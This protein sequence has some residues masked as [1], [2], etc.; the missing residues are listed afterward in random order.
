[1]L[2]Q[3]ATHSNVS[4]AKPMFIERMSGVGCGRTGRP[5]EEGF[6]SA[7]DVNGV[8]VHCQCGESITLRGDEARDQQMLSTNTFSRLSAASNHT[9]S[10]TARIPPGQA[11]E[12]T[13]ARHFD[14]PCRAF[15]TPN[16]PVALK[17]AF[18]SGERIQIL[19]SLLPSH[20]TVPHPVALFW[21]S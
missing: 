10:G 19:S 21:L 1:M 6:Q 5:D 16:A 9:E 12:V 13:F 8:V 2:A 4:Q 7:T 14:F 17:E 3:C 18:L 11:Y 15:L 20:H